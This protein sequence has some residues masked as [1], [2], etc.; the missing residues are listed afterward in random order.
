MHCM[1]KRRLFT[2]DRWF[3]AAARVEYL[4]VRNVFGLQVN[5]IRHLFPTVATLSMI[6]FTHLL[7]VCSFA[8]NSCVVQAMNAPTLST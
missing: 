3:C 1:K 8:G 2:L 7:I 6:D 5:L 4:N